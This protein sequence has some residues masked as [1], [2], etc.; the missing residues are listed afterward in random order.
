MLSHTSLNWW[1][2]L[3]SYQQCGEAEDLQSSG[4][5][6]FP[7]HP[8]FGSPST[9][10][11]YDIFVNSEAQ[12]P[13]CYRG[14]D[15]LQRVDSNHR[16]PAYETGGDG[17]TPLLCD[18]FGGGDK[19]RTCYILLAK[20]ALSQMSYTPIFN[21]VGVQG[22]EPWTSS[23]Q[24]MRTTGLFYTPKYWCPGRDSNSQLTASKTAVF[25]NFTT[26]ALHIKTHS[27]PR[28]GRHYTRNGL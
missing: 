16:S 21:L 14:I 7:T 25:T 19:D 3:E 28:H 17:R 6:S 27:S 12:L 26:G 8:Y 20:Q 4:V 22:F 2:R 10:R 18:I 9:D 11:T 15:W 5:T 23:S 24:T 1:M 13:L